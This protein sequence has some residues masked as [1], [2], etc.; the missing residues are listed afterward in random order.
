[1]KAVLELP[2][3]RKLRTA[4]KCRYVLVFDHPEAKPY[5]LHR[6]DGVKLDHFVR[7]ARFAPARVV[8]DTETGKVIR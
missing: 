3:G 6:T 5:I 1:M 4:T 8:I 7:V 2:S